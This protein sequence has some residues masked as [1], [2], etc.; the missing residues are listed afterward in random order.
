MRLGVKVVLVSIGL[1]VA[2]VALS[3]VIDVTPKGLVGATW[4]G[5]PLAWRYVIVYPGSPVNYHFMNFLLDVM[6]W[7]I[8][9]AAIG[10]LL[11]LI[12]GYI[13]K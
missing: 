2:I 6:A 3:G 10:G 11:F 7:F 13:R 4:Y 9:I 12:P 5:W 1:A 8:P